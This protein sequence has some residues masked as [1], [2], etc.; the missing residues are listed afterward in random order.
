MAVEITYQ[1]SASLIHTAKSQLKKIGSNLK[2]TGSNY[3]GAICDLFDHHY[4]VFHI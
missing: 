3:D 4:N 1:Y 2:K